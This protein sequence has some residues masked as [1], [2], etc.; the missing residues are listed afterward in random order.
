MKLSLKIRTIIGHIVS[1]KA[2]IYRAYAFIWVF[3]VT[4]LG[5]HFDCHAFTI[6]LIIVLGKTILYGIIEFTHY[7]KELL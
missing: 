1:K 4:W 5:L 3:S 2:L 7:P 6:A